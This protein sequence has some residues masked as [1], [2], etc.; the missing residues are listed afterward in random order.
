MQPGSRGPQMFCPL[1]TH[2]PG[3]STPASEM[4]HG[5]RR[6]DLP[7]SDVSF[8]LELSLASLTPRLSA[9]PHPLCPRQV[10]GVFHWQ[11]QKEKLGS[12]FLSSPLGS[13]LPTQARVLPSTPCPRFYQRPGPREGSAALLRLR[14]QP[15][16][17]WRF[18]ERALSPRDINHLLQFVSH[19]RDSSAPV[20]SSFALFP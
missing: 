10:E 5:W 9:S 2:Y 7:A 6:A 18:T 4:S 14:G 16:R 11:I 1:G 3:P 19:E 17:C 8:H 12:P 13:R 15:A 20:T